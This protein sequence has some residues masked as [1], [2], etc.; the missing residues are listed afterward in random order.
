MI[1][2]VL[3]VDQFAATVPVHHH[4]LLPTPSPEHA[5]TYRSL[6]VYLSNDTLCEQR[7]Q[8]AITLARRLDAHLVGLAP[9]GLV[10]LP[11]A[12]E[13]MG[14]LGE[15]SMLAYNTLRDLATEAA[16]QFRTSCLAAGL[17][18]H[19][20]VVDEA[21]KA[22][23]LIHHAHCSDLCILSQA[24]PAAFG[25]AEA[26]RVLEQVLLH[27][28]RPT[29][30]LPYTGAGTSGSLGR[31]AL[32]AWDDSREAA[33]ALSDALPL[34]RQAEQVNVLSFS[35][36]A[37][38]SDTTEA[39]AKRLGALQ[40]WLMWQGVAAEV[41]AE[42]TEVGVGDAILSRASDLGADLIVMGAYGHTRFTERVLGGATR[43]LLG[44]MTAP[45]VMSH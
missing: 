28:A 31:S 13:P 2:P 44:S 6:L 9:T 8:A 17:R 14:S 35:E 10:N 18:S 12:M 45:V 23:S 4:G 21:D 7:T 37:V 29:L 5:M 24:D 1:L 43:R 25:Q 15:F 30:L 22:A 34:L 38:S 16:E 20:A 26:Q 33:R 19:E 42:S 40:R 39:L 41:H 36:G 3:V 11:M 32:V 27:S